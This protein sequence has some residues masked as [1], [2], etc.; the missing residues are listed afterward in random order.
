VRIILD[1]AASRTKS[2]PAGMTNSVVDL[3][4]AYLG[5]QAGLGPKPVPRRCGGALF[6]HAWFDEPVPAGKC[7]SGLAWAPGFCSVGSSS[8]S[9]VPGTTAPLNAY[10]QLTQNGGAYKRALATDGVCGP[11]KTVLSETYVHMWEPAYD[12]VAGS[13]AILSTGGTVVASND[14]VSPTDKMK[15]FDN[16]GSTKWLAVGSIAPSLTYDFSGTTSRVLTNYSIGAGDIVAQ[17]PSGWIVEGSNDAKTWK[18]LQTISGVNFVVRNAV[19]GYALSN[20]TAYQMY[21]FRFTG[22]HGSADTA[23]SELRLLGH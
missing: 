21:R 1:D 20:T 22:N 14:G 11:M 13:V 7:D 15:A 6:L 5:W 9:T 4:I 8:W 2:M 16:S 19:I 18:T 23:V 17:D 3:D 12:F 10:M